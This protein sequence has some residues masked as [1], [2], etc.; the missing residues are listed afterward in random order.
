MTNAEWEYF[1]STM[2]PIALLEYGEGDGGELMEKKMPDA[3]LVKIAGAGHFPWL[4]NPALCGAV[5]RSY[6]KIG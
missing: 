4:N 6:L 5:I 2:P 3:G 1:K